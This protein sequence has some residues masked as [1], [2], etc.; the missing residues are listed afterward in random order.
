MVAGLYP[1][2]FRFARM[3]LQR[4]LV[5]DLYTVVADNGVQI[6]VCA[7]LIP[8]APGTAGRRAVW[9]RSWSGAQNFRPFSETKA[10]SRW[11]RSAN[12]AAAA[13]RFR[14]K[15]RLS[16]PFRYWRRSGLS[17]TPKPCSAR[18]RPGSLPHRARGTVSAILWSNTAAEPYS[19]IC[20]VIIGDPAEVSFCGILF[21][22]PLSD[23]RFR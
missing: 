15:L 9:K 16:A 14:Q 20:F 2:R 5:R 17:R 10:R 19:P 23:V 21:Y 1:G 12:S 18:S 4:C 22:F 7:Q 13:G 6:A 8:A 11:R 3:V